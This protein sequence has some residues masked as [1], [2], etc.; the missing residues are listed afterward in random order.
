MLY[1][2]EGSVRVRTGAL[3]SQSQVLDPAAASEINTT[4]PI[5]DT[6]TMTAKALRAYL[7]GQQSMLRDFMRH[8]ATN[9]SDSETAHRPPQ[10]GAAA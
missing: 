2:V 9:L 10:H 8:P 3:W 1:L 4:P 5:A 6:D 7:E